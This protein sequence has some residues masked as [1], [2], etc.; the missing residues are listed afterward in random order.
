VGII[1]K[2]RTISL[3]VHAS[4]VLLTIIRSRLKPHIEANL[5]EEQAGFRAD[6]STVEQ[7]FV[8]RQLAERYMEVQDGNLVNVFIDF[9]KAFDRVWH[10]GLLRVLQHYNIPRKLI[11]LITSLYSQAVSAVR[12]GTDISDWFRQ[13]VGVRQGCILSPDLFNLFLDHVLAEALEE[14]QGGATMNG[15]RVSNLRFAD[16]IDLMGETVEET[17]ELLNAIHRSSQKH[18]LEISKEKTNVLLV[19]K[20]A[21]TVVIK[22]D[23]DTLKQVSHFKYLGTEVTEQNSS[24]LDIK[25][26]LAQALAG[27]SNLRTVWQNNRVTLTTK[28]RLLD[29]LVLPIALYGCEAWTLTKS[30]SNKIS[31]FGMKCLRGVLNITWR[32]HITNQD[33]AAR[34]SREEDYF[35]RIVKERQLRWLGH[36]L[37]LD[38][39][40]LPK[41]SLEAHSHGTRY[42]GRPRIS[43][44]DATLEGTGVDLKEAVQLAQDRNIWRRWH[45]GVYDHWS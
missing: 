25:C 21:R 31:A 10:A 13:T 3:I 23:N 8:W 30:D 26:R 6:R 27:L 18:G 38:D 12:S 20:D 4:K 16:D 35:L 11:A 42:R 39:K 15:Q 5:A 19:A 22:I 32:D 44:I 28:L 36:V 37:R 43:W 9:K 34:V 2:V 45:H 29:C 1:K 7:I 33:V 40:R 24:S 17:Q 41:T 14:Y